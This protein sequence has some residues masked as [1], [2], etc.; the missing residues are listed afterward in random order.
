MM[1]EAVDQEGNDGQ[2]DTRG[3]DADDG[4]INDAERI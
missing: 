2:P 4:D 3:D 1:R